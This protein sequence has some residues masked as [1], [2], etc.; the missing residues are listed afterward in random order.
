MESLTR[1]TFV[2]NAAGIATIAHISPPIALPAKRVGQTKHSYTLLER[3]L[4]VMRT[5]QQDT[6]IIKLLICAISVAASA[7]PA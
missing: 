2:Y 7:K 1:H 3:I 5:A 6:S 4:P